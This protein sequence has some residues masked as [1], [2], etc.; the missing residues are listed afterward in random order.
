MNSDALTYL[1]EIV[2]GVRLPNT[3]QFID[4]SI[5]SLPYDDKFFDF[6][7]CYGVL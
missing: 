3:P 5:E 6:V 2:D 1:D 4:G 7:L